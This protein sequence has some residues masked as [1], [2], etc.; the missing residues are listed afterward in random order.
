[1]AGKLCGRAACYGTVEPLSIVL[2]HV[3][4]QLEMRSAGTS[5]PA[6]VQFGLVLRGG[7]HDLPLLDEGVPFP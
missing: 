6:G 3:E 2:S 4:L 1:M 7:L 5:L